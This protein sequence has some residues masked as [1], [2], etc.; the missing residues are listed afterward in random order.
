MTTENKNLGS[1]PRYML[2]PLADTIL[3]IYSPLLALAFS[4]ALILL[5]KPENNQLGGASHFIATVLSSVFVHAHL[6]LVFARTHLNHKIFSQFKWRFTLIPIAIF[7]VQLFSPFVTEVF[8]IVVV[9]WDV[10]HSSQQTYGIGRIFDRLDGVEVVTHPRIERFWNLVIY[11]GPIFFGASMHV[12][13]MNFNSLK[14]FALSSLAAIPGFASTYEE[15]I[16]YIA[17]FVTVATTVAMINTLP[18]VSFRAF[19]ISRKGLLYLSTGIT[20]ILSWGTLPPVYA[21]FVMN[22][23][24]ALQYFAIVWWSER[25]NFGTLLKISWPT[26]MIAILVGSLVLAGSF[27][28][29]AGTQILEHPEWVLM[30]LVNTVSLMH[31]WYDGFVWRGPNL[32]A[33]NLVKTP[34]GMR[35]GIA[36]CPDRD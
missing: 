10:F 8:F 34:G 6:I 31:F 28:Y 9:W 25:R 2:S 3:F 5:A 14:P 13:L 33:Q 12:H 23:F 15:Y 18:N 11:A 26:P 29:G 20:S 1:R 30:S 32:L 24:H 19:K 27:I 21:F 4:I 36:F 35:S 17:I 22:F 16:R 7:V